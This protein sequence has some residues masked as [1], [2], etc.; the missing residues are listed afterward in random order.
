MKRYIILLSSLIAFSSLCPAGSDGESLFSKAKD[1]AMAAAADID[2]SKLSW[3]KVSGIPYDD[4]TQLVAWASSQVDSWK[5]KLTN[6]AKQK[7]LSGLA[8][9]GDSGWEGAL[10]SVVSA[11]DSVRKSNP[12]TWDAAKGALVSAWGSFEDKA[13]D[14]LGD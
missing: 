6:A 13:I 4:K 9:L 3:D 5:G 12:D 8:N 7:G 1:S 10:K 14:Y 2:W 11:L